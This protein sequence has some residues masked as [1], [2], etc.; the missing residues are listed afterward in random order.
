MYKLAIFDLDGTLVNSLGDLADA[1]NAALAERGYPTHSEDSYRYMVGN[2]AARLC[3]RAL[4]EGHRSAEDIASLQRRFG[5]IYHGCCLVRTRPY[6]GIPELIKRLREAG[7]RCAVASNKPDSFSKE[8]VLALLGE[9]SFDLVMGKREGVPTKPD[10]EIVYD[11]MKALG[12]E[13]SGTVFIGDSCVDVQTAHNAGLPCIGCLW[14]FRGEAELREN[15][16][17][18]LAGSPEEIYGL[19]VMHNA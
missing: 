17:D 15:G 11:I 7:V 13:K 16:C 5:E 19:A 12:A 1:V 14:G 4:P 8:I 6:E 2:G 18:M 10:P 3:E 9:G